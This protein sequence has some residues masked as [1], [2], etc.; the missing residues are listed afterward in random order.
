MSL[1]ADQL[2][3]YSR[4]IILPQIGTE[5]QERLL[6]AHVLIVGAGGL[7]C[8]VSLYLTAAGIGHIGLIDPD[9]VDVSNLQRQVLYTHDDVGQFK[10]EAARRRLTA[11]NP[12]VECTIYPERLS[13]DNALDL[14]SSYDYVVDGT[15]NFPTRYLVNDACVMTGRINVY[16]SIYRFDGQASVFAHPEGPCYRCL[17]PEPPPPGSVPN[18]AEGGVLGVLPGQIGMIQATETVKL[19]AG[20]GEPLIGRLLCLDALSMA[21][22]EVRIKRH[23]QCP[24]CGDAPSI[25]EL[26][27]ETVACEV[28]EAP[29]GV[30]R[31]A[32]EEAK[33]RLARGDALLLDVR[34][35][36]EYEIAHLPDARLIPLNSLLERMDELPADR[37]RPIV[38]YCH[39]G[40]RSMQ[41]L[42]LLS[43]RGF[44]RLA[45]LEG[46][47]D[48]WSQEVDPDVPRY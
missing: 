3:R 41:A 42:R 29:G 2:R 12:D 7:G 14:V 28:E 13:A 24:V 19:I 36:Y 6:S 43:R 44:R 5:G 8:P 23:S 40:V 17:L 25:T 37:D 10:V 16:G 47:I 46:G 15:D 21:W 33:K 4:H 45:N 22:S 38:A 27:E 9:R 31:L 35:P 18:C 30:E 39:H 26:R 34:E 11:L 1:H 32:P 20:I 48:R